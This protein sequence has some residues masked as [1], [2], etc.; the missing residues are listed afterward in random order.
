ML[1]LLLGIIFGILAFFTSF[2]ITYDE[3]QR[4]FINKKTALRHSFETG[5]FAFFLF[6]TISILVGFLFNNIK[7]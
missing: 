5:A 2:L 7:F 3:Y 4:H 6:L 1:F